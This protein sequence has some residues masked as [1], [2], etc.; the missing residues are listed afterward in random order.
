M[1]EIFFSEF[2]TFMGMLFFS[3]SE[4]EKS[5]KPYSQKKKKKTDKSMIHFFKVLNSYLEP[6]I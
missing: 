1:K 3:R 4:Y 5:G 6:E 2:S